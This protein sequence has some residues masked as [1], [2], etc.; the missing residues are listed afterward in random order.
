MTDS[1]QTILL[2]VI[3]I[4]TILLVVLGIQVFLILR[5]IRKTVE[6]TNKVLDDT[7]TITGSI[8]TPVSTLSSLVMGIKTGV[9]LANWLKKTYA[10]LLQQ[11]PF[12]KTKGLS[13]EQSKEAMA[14]EEKTKEPN[15]DTKTN[16]LSERNKNP[17]IRRFFRGISR[18]SSV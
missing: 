12:K 15:G 18:K 16:A 5:E 8:A 6:K 4:L 1:A 7:G 10:L 13:D 14:S 3:V 11:T 2:L 9:S 17:L